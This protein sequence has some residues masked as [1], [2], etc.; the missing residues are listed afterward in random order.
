[1]L[2]GPSFNIYVRDHE[3][4]RAL[5]K[6]DVD[7]PDIVQAAI[8]SGLTEAAE[9]VK[10]A[11]KGPSNFNRGFQVIKN[12]LM[13]EPIEEGGDKGATFFSV[14]QFTGGRTGVKGRD[15]SFKM[16]EA[17]E[18]GVKRATYGF[19]GDLGH[20]TDKYA[21]SWIKSDATPAQ[22]PK[23]AWLEKTRRY[24]EQIIPERINK[25]VQHYLDSGQILKGKKMPQPRDRYGRY[26]KY[27]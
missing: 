14:D 5:K 2:G 13:V 15:G 20:T 8:M 10:S 1:M 16:A 4:K 27:K 19:K 7:G 18:M 17:Y 3:L 24:A 9:K 25:F 26:T 6:L 11:L 22:I 23:L 21:E 12:S